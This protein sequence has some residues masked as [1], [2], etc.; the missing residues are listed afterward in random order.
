MQIRWDL[1]GLNDILK[2]SDFSLVVDGNLYP[3]RHG[4]RSRLKGQL[5]IKIS[6]VLPYVLDLV[7]EDIR[8]DAAES[9]RPQ[10]PCQ[11]VVDVS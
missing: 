7:P 6:C 1:Q 11:C 4:N 9:V 2:P 3:E 8:R 10:N 5:E